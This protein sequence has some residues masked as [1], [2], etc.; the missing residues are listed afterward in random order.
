MN[1]EKIKEFDRLMIPVME[2]LQS[3]PHPHFTI[4]SSLNHSELLEGQLTTNKHYDD[5]GKELK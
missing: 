2:F 5:E 4:I 1:E 3:L